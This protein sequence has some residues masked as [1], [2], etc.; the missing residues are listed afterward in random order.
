MANLFALQTL[1]AF[2]QK[3]RNLPDAKAGMGFWADGVWICQDD[4]LEK[5]H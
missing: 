1:E 4:T 2:L 5:V 3:L